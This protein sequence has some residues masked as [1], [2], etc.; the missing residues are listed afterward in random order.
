M[1]CKAGWVGEGFRG[2]RGPPGGALPSVGLIPVKDPPLGTLHGMK[3]GVIFFSLLKTPKMSLVF[4]FKVKL[5][6]YVL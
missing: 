2:I 1:P 5:N 4:S 3:I 6:C